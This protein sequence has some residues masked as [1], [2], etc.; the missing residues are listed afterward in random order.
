MFSWGEMKVMYFWQKYT[1]M[2]FCPSQCI[3][4]GVRD[5]P[6]TSC[7]GADSDHLVKVLSAL[8]LQKVIVFPLAINKCARGCSKTDK[9]C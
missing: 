8:A 9:S 4:S 2:M 7:S 5:A 3:P 6:G 1:S